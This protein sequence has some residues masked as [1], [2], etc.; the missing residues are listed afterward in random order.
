MKD[1]DVMGKELTEPK[2]ENLSPVARRIKNFLDALE[3]Y[4]FGWLF[5]LVSFLLYGPNEDLHKISKAVTGPAESR[6]EKLEKQNREILE[7]LR[8]LQN[9][10][11]C[12]KRKRR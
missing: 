12:L 11:D 5:K 9:E 8:D 7:H 4:G 3:K 10:V 2:S 1:S 6:L